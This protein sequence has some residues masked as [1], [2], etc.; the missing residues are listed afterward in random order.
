MPPDQRPVNWSPVYKS[1][2]NRLR[3]LS[4]TVNGGLTVWGVG[5]NGLVVRGDGTT[6]N[7]VNAPALNAQL[8]ALWVVSSS[9]IWVCDTAGRRLLHHGWRRLVDPVGHPALCAARHLRPVDERCHGGWRQQHQRPSLRRHCVERAMHSLG[10]LAYGVWS[11]SM[12]WYVVGANGKTARAIN[13]E[14]PA[15]W[16]QIPAMATTHLRFIS[17]QTGSDQYPLAVGDNG[18]VQYIHPA[19]SM[20]MGTGYLG[21]ATNLTST[22]V[23]ST[24]FAHVAGA[25]GTVWQYTNGP[26]YSRGN[27]NIANYNLTGIW[28]DGSGGIWVA[29]IGLA[30]DPG[31]IWKY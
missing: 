24:G 30:S 26:W 11:G 15:S 9:T 21:G 27:A 14:A 2:M 7:A 17:G 20:W 28:G 5:D 6:F 3:A 16:V 18:A 31:G 29:G 1:P 8:T 10:D 25:A 4:G 23:A 22:W 12:Y 19:T 13:P